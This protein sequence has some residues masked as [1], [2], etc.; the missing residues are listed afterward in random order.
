[1]PSRS[2]IRAR[3]PENREVFS[4]TNLAPSSMDY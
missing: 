3:T 2:K 1:V 4:P